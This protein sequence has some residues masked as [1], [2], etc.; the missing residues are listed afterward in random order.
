MTLDL[1]KARD[2]L[3]RYD[4]LSASDEATGPGPVGVTCEFVV[5]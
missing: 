4:E 1:E 3:R 2:L 5:S